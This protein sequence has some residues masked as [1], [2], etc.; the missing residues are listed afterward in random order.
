[1]IMAKENFIKVEQV[2]Y[3]IREEAK[4]R[5]ALKIFSRNIVSLSWNFF[6]FYLGSSNALPQIESSRTT[7]YFI[8]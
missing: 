3:Y 7:G 5:L 8:I 4:M 1:M 6:F 2:I